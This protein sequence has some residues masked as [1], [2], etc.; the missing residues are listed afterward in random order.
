M[1]EKKGFFAEFKEFALKGNVIDL[2]VGVIIGG[3]FGTITA[4]L[5]NDVVMPFV[6][7]FLGGVNFE[8]WAFTLGP[9]F[10]G[11]EPQ[12]IAIGLFIQ[13]VVNFLVL[14]LVIF[15][16]I[17]QVNRMR[18]AA[19][20]KKLAAQPAPEPA[21]EAEP[22]PTSEELLAQILEELKKAK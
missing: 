18:A 10:P 17:R 2:A 1:S 20:A 14:A 16:M 9:I 7:L 11:A 6:G 21:P 15:V 5:I 13:S 4:S 3:A 22:G 19:E 8:T 12:T